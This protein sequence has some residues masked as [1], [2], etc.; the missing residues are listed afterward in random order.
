MI[1]DETVAYARIVPFDNLSWRPTKTL[2]TL[3]SRGWSMVEVDPVAEII[4][5]E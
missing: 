5:L 1:E 4:S 3:R 2:P